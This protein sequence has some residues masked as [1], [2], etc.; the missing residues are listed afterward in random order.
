MVREKFDELS[1][2]HNDAAVDQL[3]FIECAAFEAGRAESVAELKA[4]IRRACNLLGRERVLL[5]PDCGFATFA[6][7]PVSSMEI[8]EAKL[9]ALVTAAEDFQRE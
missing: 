7:N 3:S 6:D 5:N 2:T 9:L 1:A 4:A 8:A